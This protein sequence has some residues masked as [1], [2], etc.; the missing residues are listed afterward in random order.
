ML[1]PNACPL[2]IGQNQSIEVLKDGSV[3]GYNDPLLV[4]KEWFVSSKKTTNCR[5]NNFKAFTIMR[6]L[7]VVKH[8]DFKFPCS[9]PSP[10]K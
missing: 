6:N 1:F 5:C 8:I 2:T 7:P 4:K 3:G 10:E 9:Y